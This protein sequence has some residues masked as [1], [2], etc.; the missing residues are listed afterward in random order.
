[1]KTAADDLL[2]A[3]SSGDL[4]AVSAALE[5]GANVNAKDEHNN[6]PLNG[7][8]L[9]GH[10]DVVKRLLEAGADVENKGSGGGLTPLANA[11]SRGHFDIAQL[12]VD[13]G[14]RVTDDLLSV[15]QTKVNI[16]EE[17]AERGMVTEE[18]ITAWKEVLAFF[19][20]QRLKQDLPDAVP[21]L[22]SSDA[23]VRKHAVGGMAEAAKQGLDVT[24]A[25]SALPALLA[26]ADADVRASASCALT[27]H[28]ARALDW[29]GVHALLASGDVRVR[30]AAAEALVRIE[31]A[32]ASLVRSMGALL[33]D[34]EAEVRKTAAVAVATLPRKGVDA[35]S[36]LPRMIELLADAEPSVRRSAAF[37]FSMWSKRG[38]RD[39]CAPALS[40]LRSAAERDENDAVRQFAARAVADLEVV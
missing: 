36:L 18:G 10:L 9:F 31:T 32:D 16:L 2:K 13:R 19:V 11:A 25:A 4:G 30:T 8:A 20:T 1:M 5:G 22:A 14:A 39:Y 37:A 27:Y 24:A 15:L 17:N 33:Q 7:A 29:P 21:L 35:T 40:A 12:L 23:A 3:A 34:G 6:T 28:R 38:L 26:D